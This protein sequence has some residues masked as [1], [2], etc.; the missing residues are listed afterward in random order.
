VVVSDGKDNGKNEIQG[1]FASLRM[2]KVIEMRKVIWK[3]IE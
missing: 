3:V 1:S 2:T